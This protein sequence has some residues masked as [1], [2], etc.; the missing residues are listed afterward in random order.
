[1]LGPKQYLFPER[2]PKPPPSSGDWAM[3]Y[4]MCK[5]FDRPPRSRLTDTPYYPYCK[6]QYNVTFQLNYK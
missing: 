3:E 2:A 1:M 4:L 5:I 6:N